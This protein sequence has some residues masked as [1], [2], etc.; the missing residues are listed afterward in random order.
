MRTSFVVAFVCGVALVLT[1]SAAFADIVYL[2]GA[3]KISGRIVNQTETSVEVDVGAGRVTVS[4]TSVDHI[5]KGRSALDEY[6]ERAAKLGPRDREG[7]IALAQWASSQGLGVQAR[8]AYEN[9]L[10][11]EPNDPVANRALGRVQLDGRWVSEDEAYQA[12]GYVRFEGQW[13][14]PAEQQAILQQRTAQAAN[15]RAQLDAEARARDAE[16][17]AQ[18]AEARAKEAEARAAIPHRH[19]NM[20]GLGHGPGHLAANATAPQAAASPAGKSSAVANAALGHA[21]GRISVQQFG[22][23]RRWKSPLGRQCCA[24]IVFDHHVDRERGDHRG[25][26]CEHDSDLEQRRGG[27]EHLRAYRQ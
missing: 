21:A 8:R 22:I 3:G 17:R 27:V 25:K 19:P 10:R 14:T 23:Q 13:I 18:E 5:E 4:M 24:S 6:D 2:K 11:V 15:D 7:W 1:S 26:H 16:A 9:V 12:R 20:V